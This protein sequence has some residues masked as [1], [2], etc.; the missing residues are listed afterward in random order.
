MKLNLPN[1]NPNK[2]FELYETLGYSLWM[3]QSLELA[4]SHYLVLAHKISS[5]TAISQV[6][7]IFEQTSKKTFGF[8]LNDL[9]K[10]NDFLSEIIIKKLADILENRN[11]LVHKVYAINQSDMFSKSKSD[12][13][14]SKIRTIGDDAIELSKLI[15]R[16]TDEVTT[17]KG[18]YTIEE[19]D[20][21]TQEI[22][23]SWAKDN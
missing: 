8:L 15:S 17:K 5:A 2:V 7:Q 1:Y 20:R 16:K 3:I 19:L 22:L 18:F 14:I 11:W 21:K 4:L 13:L 10:S 9:K 6:Q 23:N 12:K